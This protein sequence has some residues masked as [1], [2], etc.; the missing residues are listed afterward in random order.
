VPSKL[1]APT[2][3]VFPVALGNDPG[4]MRMSRPLKNS[5][6]AA[7]NPNGEVVVQSFRL[8]QM[9]M[10]EI[11]FLKMDCEGSEYNVVLGGLETIKR[12]RPAVII[13]QHKGWANIQGVHQFG[14]LKLLEGLGMKVITKFNSDYLLTF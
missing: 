14:A 12:N 13:E 3:N 7:I 10:D 2:V 5:G 1:N 6:N 4:E 8:D 11:D 9:A